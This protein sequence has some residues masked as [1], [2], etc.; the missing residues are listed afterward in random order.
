[1]FSDAFTRDLQLFSADPCRNTYLAAALL[2]RGS[3]TASDIRRNIERLQQRLHFVPWN[4][5]GWKVGHCLVPPIGLP[6]SL[7]ALSNN[8]AIRERF[9]DILE[10]F[11]KLYKRKAHLHHYTNVDNFDPDLFK[12]S[13]D[14]LE[15]LYQQ[16]DH[17]EKQSELGIMPRLPRLQISD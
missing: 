11:S 14:S 12:V 2:M 10:R 3:V 15:D 16:Y 8:T 4:R 6:Y 1:M 17:L 7:L 9:S 13:S 5:E